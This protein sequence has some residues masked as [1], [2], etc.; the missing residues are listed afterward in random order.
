MEIPYQLFI[1]F[2][3]L[4]S[5]KRHRGI[6]FNTAISVGG[7]A[8]GVMALLVVL[9]VMSGFHEDLQTKILGANAHAVVLNYRGGIEDYGGLIE[10]LRG[11][12]HVTAFS[13]FVIGQVMVSSGKR[14]H[15]V[16]LRGINLQDELKTTDIFKHLKEGSLSDL[17]DRDGTP[18][19]ALGRE[20]ATT[21]GVVPGEAVNVISPVGE[22]GP[23][24]MLPKVRQFKVGA[25]FEIGMFEYDANLT[26]TSLKAAQEF[27]GYGS[28]VSGIQLRLTDVYKAPSVREAISKKLG[29]P[30]YVKDWMQMNRNLFSALKLEKFAMFV[31]LILIVLVASFNIVSTL[32][33]SVIE[34]EREIA[35]LKAIGATNQGIMAVFMI[36]GLLIGTVGTAIGL[37]GAT[38][39][40]HILNTYEIIKLPADVY[41]LSRLPVKMKAFDFAV[42]SVSAV[43][44]SFLSTVYPSYQAAR[45]NPVE[46]LRYE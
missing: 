25:V 34:K 16:F 17:R 19:I 23:L 13:P 4:K 44:I 46:P 7:V 45:L 14:A 28:S 9:A 20:L 29:F 38:V 43:V 8:V 22:M 31:I 40:G 6:S 37:V 42:V 1:A 5:K 15:G 32:M 41:Y 21:L 27:F 26:L 11:E 2:R 12:P 24:G 33:M 35:I 10:K 36:Q 3:Y 18:W 30:Y 39:L